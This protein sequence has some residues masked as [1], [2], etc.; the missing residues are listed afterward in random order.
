MS[1]PLPPD[2]PV[3][4]AE[5]VPTGG[6]EG[7]AAAADGVAGAD[8]PDAADGAAGPPAHLGRDLAIYTALRFVM[9]A[10]LTGILTLFMPLVVALMF[11]IIIQLPLAWLIFARQRRKVNEAVATASASRRRHRQELR[12]ALEGGR[13]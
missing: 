5:R 13:D 3:P 7:Y 6:F 8:R 9:I 10:V 12:E 1:G 11:A 2:R 4:S